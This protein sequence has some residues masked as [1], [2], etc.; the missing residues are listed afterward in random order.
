ML[1][2]PLTFTASGVVPSSRKG[3]RG[4]FIRGIRRP[5]QSPAPTQATSGHPA[6][7]NLWHP[8]YG[9]IGLSHHEPLFVNWTDSWYDV[10]HQ[11]GL[12]GGASRAQAV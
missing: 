5:S 4:A 7:G 11:N 2:C 3:I 12:R 6:L 8:G 9:S 1:F 10:A